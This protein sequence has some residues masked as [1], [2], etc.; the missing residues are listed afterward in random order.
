MRGV[1]VQHGSGDCVQ[2]LAAAE[3][4]HR[5]YCLKHDYEGLFDRDTEAPHRHPVWNKLVLLLRTMNAWPSVQHFFV[6]DADALIVNKEIELAEALPAD[7]DIALIVRENYVNSGFVAIRNSEKVRD[8]LTD[9]FVAGPLQ[10]CN[11]G[12]DARMFEMIRKETCPVKVHALGSEWNY[13]ETYGAGI[14]SVTCTR[15]EA[16]IVA[17]HGQTRDVALKA[18]QQKIGELS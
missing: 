16:H 18:M 11:H 12:I 8:W 10:N 5:A 6:L 15:A 14:R 17:W 3:P 9:L 2:L 4:W 13:F 1:L 7:A